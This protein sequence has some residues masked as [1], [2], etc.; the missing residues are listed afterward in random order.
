MYVREARLPSDFQWLQSNQ[1]NPNIERAEE[2]IRKLET[3]KEEMNYYESKIKAI[4]ERKMNE[5]RKERDY[6]EGQLVWI[7]APL[8]RL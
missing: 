7:H 1:G 3:T 2:L 5:V 4:K 6:Q 8:W